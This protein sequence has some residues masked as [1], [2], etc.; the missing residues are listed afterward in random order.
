MLRRFL[1]VCHAAELNPGEIFAEVFPKTHYDPDLGMTVP[2]GGL[3][4]IVKQARVYS[5]ESV[6]QPH[7][8]R[9]WLEWL[10]ETRYDDPKRVLKA[11]EAAIFSVQREDLPRLLGVWASAC[12]LL[13]RHE[14]AFLTLREAFGL[15]RA[16]TDRLEEADLLFARSF[17]GLFNLSKLL[18]SS[19]Y[20]RKGW[21][22]CLRE[23]GDMNGLGE[24]PGET[25]A[26]PYLSRSLY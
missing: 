13:C 25:G 20:R 21:G 3:P 12:R 7:V 8:A 26:L 22:H 14:E 4:W 5:A 16:G 10:D 23:N 17:S 15:A 2:K 19:K 9:E 11:A 6:Q 24:G 18:D 1:R